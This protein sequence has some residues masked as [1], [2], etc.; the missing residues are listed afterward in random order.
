M[1]ATPASPSPEP[2]P[3][4]PSVVV[5]AAQPRTA[6]TLPSKVAQTADRV[7]APLHLRELLAVVAH[8]VKVDL[9]DPQAAAARQR[10]VEEVVLMSR[11]KAAV[12]N[13]M[14]GTVSASTSPETLLITAPVVAVHSMASAAE[15]GEVTEPRWYHPFSQLKGPSLVPVAEVEGR[16][17]RPPTANLVLGVS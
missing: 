7:A 6:S 2:R 1:A 10:A 3:S 13:P 16:A 12:P 4:S 14:A 17:A 8:Q 5:A 15:Q 11:A 9:E